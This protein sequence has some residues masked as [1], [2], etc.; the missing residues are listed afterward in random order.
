MKASP[1]KLLPPK[2]PTEL[3]EWLDGEL[4][5]GRLTPTQYDIVW[6]YILAH[7]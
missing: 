3:F 2:S 4:K 6:A 5:A 1:R 7:R